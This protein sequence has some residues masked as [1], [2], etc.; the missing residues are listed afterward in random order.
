MDSATDIA[1][2]LRPTEQFDQGFLARND[3]ILLTRLFQLRV[4]VNQFSQITQHYSTPA[5]S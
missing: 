3:P 1:S 2:I 4:I 5:G